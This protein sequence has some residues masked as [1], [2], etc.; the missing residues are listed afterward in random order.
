MKQS[1]HLGSLHPKL[2]D[3]Y[4]EAPANGLHGALRRRSALLSG[5]EGILQLGHVP[6][7]G[8]RKSFTSDSKP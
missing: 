4:Q 3:F 2:L 7:L 1:T 5:D 8:P 6:L